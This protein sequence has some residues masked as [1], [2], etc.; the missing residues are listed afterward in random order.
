MKKNYSSFLILLIAF[1]CCK[2]QSSELENRSN[3]LTTG[4]WR[5]TASTLRTILGTTDVYATYADCRKD[6]YRHFNKDGTAEL[7]E[8][9]SKCNGTDPQSQLIQWKFLNNYGGKIEMNGATFTVVKLDN[10]TFEIQTP[11]T[12]PYAPERVITF[13]R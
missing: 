11:F 12:D 1:P 5:I 6:D 7:N 8:G 4:T 3:F 10:N 13:S 9:L 2:K